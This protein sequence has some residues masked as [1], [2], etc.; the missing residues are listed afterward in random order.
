M[1]RDRKEMGELSA[2]PTDALP[3][4]PMTGNSIGDRVTVF[5]VRN[6][7]TIGRR[8]ETH[9]KLSACGAK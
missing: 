6:F 8:C 9:A 1:Q 7:G 5:R 3:A 2:P 4:L